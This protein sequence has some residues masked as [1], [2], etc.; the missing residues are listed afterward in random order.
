MPRKLPD[1]KTKKN[2]LIPS[3][4]R[5]LSMMVMA[6]GLILSVVGVLTYVSTQQ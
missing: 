3:Q 2:A 6:K 1:G 4:L 5:I